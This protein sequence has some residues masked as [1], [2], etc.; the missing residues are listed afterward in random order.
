MKNNWVSNILDSEF[1]YIKWF[2]LF[3]GTPIICIG[4]CALF[5]R[6]QPNWQY[7][8]SPLP[9]DI[10]E[11]LCMKFVDNNKNNILCSNENETYGPDFY[12][13]IEKKL[14]PLDQKGLG[15]VKV[16][17]LLELYLQI[18]ETY[19]E[20]SEYGK[21][22]TY[23]LRGDRVMNFIIYFDKNNDVKSLIMNVQAP[24]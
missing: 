11:D 23:D 21:A 2:M 9:D 18:C 12:P 8:T 24:D 5:Y 13:Y 7:Y 14:F 10:K 4:I 17:E 15:F 20:K 3:F 16:Q 19:P 22:C 1:T 6:L